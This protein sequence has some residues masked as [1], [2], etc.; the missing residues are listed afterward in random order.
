[1]F[2]PAALGL[3]AVAGAAV[4][5]GQDQL[6]DFVYGSYDGA[7]D[8][9]GLPFSGGDV[10]GAALWSTA[11]WFCNPLQ[12]LLL[13]FGFFERERP[14]DWLLQLMGRAAGLRCGACLLGACVVPAGAQHHSRRPLL[15]QQPQRPQLLPRFRSS[16]CGPLPPAPP[17]VEEV[18]YEAPAYLRAAALALVVVGGV[19]TAALLELGLG[20]ATWSVS[21]G[22]GMCLAAGVYELGRPERLSRDKAVELEGQW[23]VFGGWRA[24]GLLARRTAACQ[25]RAAARPASRSSAHRGPAG[26]DRRW[27]LRPPALPPKAA[28]DACMCL[29]RPRRSQVCGRA[30]GA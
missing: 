12:V 18:D 30:A 4:T 27:L 22:I 10:A 25:L 7:G 24:L 11:L 3:T 14:S 16:S 23:Q 2:C 20:D 29:P 15:S 1:L 26:V 5:L 17:R 21:S 9:G 6:L 8:A 19:G 13:F 28:A